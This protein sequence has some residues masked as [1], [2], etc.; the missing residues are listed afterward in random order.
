MSHRLFI[1]YLTP[2][3]LTK[4]HEGER[5][6][7]REKLFSIL[8]NSVSRFS[9]ITYAAFPHCSHP[10]LSCQPFSPPCLP[11]IVIRIVFFFFFFSRAPWLTHLSLFF[12]YIG[13]N[14]TF[15]FSFTFSLVF[16]SPAFAFFSSFLLWVRMYFFP[17]KLPLSVPVG[18]MSCGV[19]PS[20][21]GIQRGKNE[22]RSM[23]LE[24]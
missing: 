4:L 14:G 2:I 9:H 8:E 12:Y 1:F 7:K 20:M 3:L 24:G 16:A 10:L 6:R 22:D 5:L 11:L 15:F 18:E 17:L 13:Q 19:W 23:Q 21:W